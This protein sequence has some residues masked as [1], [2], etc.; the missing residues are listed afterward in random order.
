MG[1]IYI[2]QKFD[3]AD[4]DKALK[5]IT[6]F[7]KKNPGKKT[8]TMPQGTV[9]RGHVKGDLQELCKSGVKV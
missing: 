4:A 7:F 9:R 1:M 3:Q 2:Y 5:L 8:C 6:A